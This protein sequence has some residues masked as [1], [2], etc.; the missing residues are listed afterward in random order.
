MALVILVFAGVNL[1]QGTFHTDGTLLMFLL[2]LFYGAI[3]SLP[4]EAYFVLAVRRAWKRGANFDLFYPKF[5]RN[6]LALSALY[7]A[8]LVF[9]VVL[10][11]LSQQSA[12][13]RMEPGLI[14]KFLMVWA[15]L[16]ASYLPIGWILWGK[17][18]ERLDFSNW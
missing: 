1:A 13:D 9:L 10:F 14:W 7:F 17:V 18:R 8:V 15:A 16:V 3:L 11:F 2:S 5:R 12:D 6:Y 4:L